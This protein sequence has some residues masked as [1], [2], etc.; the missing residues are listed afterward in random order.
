M[1]RFSSY[2]PLHKDL[3]YY[4]AREE[5][6]DTAY[7]QL[8]GENPQKGGNYITVWAPRQCGKTWLMQQVLFRLQKDPQFDV[9]KINLENLKDETKF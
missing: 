6:I 7:K 1:R 9:L 2:G 5:L 4:S 8:M 3:H